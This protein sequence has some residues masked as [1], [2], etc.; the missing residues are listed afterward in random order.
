MPVNKIILHY[1]NPFDIVVNK[2]INVGF[3][4]LWLLYH[5]V[6]HNKIRVDTYF[7]V[8]HYKPGNW[9]LCCI[10]SIKVHKGAPI[11]SMAIWTAFFGRQG[12]GAWSICNAGRNGTVRHL[13][14]G[15]ATVYGQFPDRTISRHL[16]GWRWIGILQLREAKAGKRRNLAASTSTPLRL[17]K[18]Q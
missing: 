13:I 17:S 10:L 9:V 3:T 16:E 14:H 12:V 4:L 15:A 11:P 7:R 2:R 1:S 8:S 6:L 18:S 5:V